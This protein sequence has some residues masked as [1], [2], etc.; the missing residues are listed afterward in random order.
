MWSDDSLVRV[1]VSVLGYEKI[2]NVAYIHSQL[3]TLRKSWERKIENEKQGGG[4][5]GTR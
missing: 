3:H 2:E 5:S 4:N 1:E